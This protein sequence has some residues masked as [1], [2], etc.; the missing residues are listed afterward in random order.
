MK[1]ILEK[2]IKYCLYFWA[3][4]FTFST[5]LILWPAE[6]N[7]NEIALYFNYLFLFLILL[8]FLFYFAKYNAKDKED[9][10]NPEP[11][12]ISLIALEFFFF[13]SIFVSSFRAISIF[14]YLFFLLAALFFLFLINTK[15]YSKKIINFFLLGSLGQ[16]LIGIY[17]FFSQ[18]VF[19]CKYLGIA[20]HEAYVL[21][22]SVLE[23]E[24]GRLIRAYGGLDHPNIFAALM[25]FSL[26]FCIFLYLNNK[27]KLKSRILLFIAMALFSLALLLSFSRA[28]FLA[29]ILSLLF[30]TCFFLRQKKD[31][32]R[33]RYF[34]L[35]SFF[36]LFWLI[37]F[38][39]FH[40]L[41]LDRFDT[42]SRLEVISISEREEQ[43]KTAI[44][45]ISD[46]PYLGLGLGTY[47]KN[48]INTYPDQAIYLAEPVHNV[49][50]LL[51]AE[52]GVFALLFFLLF[53][54]FFYFKFRFSFHVYPI[55]IGLA[56]FM[57]FDH[58]L[59]SL[60]FGLLF[61]FFILA[62]A[63]RWER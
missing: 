51:W 33:S 40:P 20:P 46:N 30:L 3:L 13:L 1:R 42:T 28:A 6:N 25:F 4:S 59:F 34:S 19:A 62:L 60:P 57:I 12:L 22:A 45:I 55:F 49:P 36:F 9:D 24:Q 15:F 7:Y 50:L 27:L 48:L 38:I 63:Y 14:K 16:A 26:I 37:F 58:W 5:K 54:F 10:F 11:Y 32:A 31:P 8:L 18:K 47:S 41:I 2:I 56:V 17:Q 61:F 23:S 52:T 29:L 44:E 35:L 53:L 21:G 43:I 39:I